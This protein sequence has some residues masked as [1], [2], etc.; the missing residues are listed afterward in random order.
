MQKESTMFSS[1]FTPPDGLLCVHSHHCI[2][3]LSGKL[4]LLH[5]TFPVALLFFPVVVPFFSLIVLFSPAAV[6]TFLSC[7]GRQSARK[8]HRATLPH[9][10]ILNSPGWLSGYV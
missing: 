3:A 1:D 2:T 7:A 10:T 6:L 5:D 8:P 4:I 9:K